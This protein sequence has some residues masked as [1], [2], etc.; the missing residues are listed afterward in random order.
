MPEFWISK[1]E[2]V[3]WPE[4]VKEFLKEIL[5]KTANMELRWGVNKRYL[6]SFERQTTVY[7]VSLRIE[8][9]PDPINIAL[10][11]SRENGDIVQKRL[12]V[13]GVAD[14]PVPNDLLSAMMSVQAKIDLESASRTAERLL[15]GMKGEE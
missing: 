6:D 12:V 7:T 4:P 15:L 8:S 1:E 2:S 3:N 14:F 11:V 13:S 10:V 9:E 5:D